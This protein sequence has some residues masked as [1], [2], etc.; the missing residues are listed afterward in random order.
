MLIYK[1]KK[2]YFIRNLRLLIN[3]SK[4]A[5]KDNDLKIIK[6]IKIEIITILI[7]LNTMIYY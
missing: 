2:T 1:K 7:S 5:L 4:I 3:K 6:Q